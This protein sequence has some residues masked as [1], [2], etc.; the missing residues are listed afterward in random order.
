MCG[1]PS[2]KVINCNRPQSPLGKLLLIPSA[3]SPREGAF[4]LPMALK[5][6]TGLLHGTPSLANFYPAMR[7]ERPQRYRS[8]LDAAAP[9]HRLPDCL[10]RKNNPAGNVAD[11][12]AVSGGT[13]ELLVMASSVFA[14]AGQPTRSGRA[15]QRLASG[16]LGGRSP[17]LSLIVVFLEGFNCGKLAV[18]VWLKPMRTRIE[19]AASSG[20]HSAGWAGDG[21]DLRPG[22]LALFHYE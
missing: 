21:G 18:G 16:D 12:P 7:G 9:G 15:A 1:P 20:G 22:K 14:A 2:P 11:L 5:Y 17:V 3:Q 13:G 4:S 8:G 10:R 6:P 19:H